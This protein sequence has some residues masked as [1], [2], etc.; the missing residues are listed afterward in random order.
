MDNETP[1]EI[2]HLLATFYG[3]SITTGTVLGVCE[4]AGGGGHSAAAQR[5]LLYPVFVKGFSS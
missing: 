4:G 2:F 5:S 3:L 1:I